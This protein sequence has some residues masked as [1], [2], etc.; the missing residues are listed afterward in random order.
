MAD[1]KIS[2]LTALTGANLAAT[3]LIPVVDVSATTAGS[4]Q[5]TI[6]EFLTGILGG[7]SV[8]DTTYS[9]A[10]AATFGWS[11]DLLLGRE[12]AGVLGIQNTASGLLAYNVTG[13]NYERGYMRWTADVFS[14]GTE[15]TGTGT[16][17]GM[18][19]LTPASTNMEFKTTGGTS[20][21]R[22]NSDSGAVFGTAMA[23]VWSNVSNTGDIGATG[24]YSPRDIF[25]QRN[26]IPIATFSTSQTTGFINIPGAAGIPSGVPSNTQGFPLYYDSTNN[27]IYVYNGSWRSTAALT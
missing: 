20:I 25:Y 23:L 11:T 4:K 24:G 18:A 19:F 13:A 17:R 21:V 3:D 5:M 27:K 6:D 7:T 8:M 26:L 16:N 2:A 9:L 14:I 22:F 15:K 1:A 10:T 12:A